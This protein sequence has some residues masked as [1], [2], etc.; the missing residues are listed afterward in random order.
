MEDHG[1]SEPRG[2][3]AKGSCWEDQTCRFFAGFNKISIVERPQKAA[4]LRRRRGLRI[5][6]VIAIRSNLL[7][8]DEVDKSRLQMDSEYQA[9]VTRF[10]WLILCAREFR[11]LHFSNPSKIHVEG[12]KASQCSEGENGRREKVSRDLVLAHSLSSSSQHVHSI[13][14]FS[15]GRNVFKLSSF[16]TT[17][18][19]LLL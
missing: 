14:F 18:R 4:R 2:S 9:S 17:S 10:P 13:P 15:L 8:G 7:L 16:L 12:R 11:V 19:C 6:V 3:G 5:S 1:I